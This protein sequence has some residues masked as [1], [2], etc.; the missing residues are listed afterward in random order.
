[1]RK[2]KNFEYVK[3]K[4]YSLTKKKRTKF[5]LKWETC[6]RA[7]FL[8][9]WMDK[10]TFTEWNVG[11]MSPIYGMSFL[12]ASRH[13][14]RFHQ[15]EELYFHFMEWISN[16]RYVRFCFGDVVAAHIPTKNI[17]LKSYIYC[18]YYMYADTY[19][20]YNCVV[21]PTTALQLL[22]ISL[23]IIITFLQNNTNCW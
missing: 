12:Q 20:R 18:Y 6:V 11:A 19:N 14:K 15:V 2:K 13:A 5:S 21:A 4:F 1:M 17:W 8:V 10:P 23:T 7:F 3:C 22:V 9:V 16:S